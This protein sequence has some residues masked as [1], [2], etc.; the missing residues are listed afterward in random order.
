M[1]EIEKK[2]L[3]HAVMLYLSTTYLSFSLAVAAYQ[4]G[5]K[6]DHLCIRKYLTYMQNRPGMTHV[7]IDD[8]LHSTVF[9][10]P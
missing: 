2:T 1:I 6:I 9:S 4:H 5:A 7:C 3:F 10:F 8:Q